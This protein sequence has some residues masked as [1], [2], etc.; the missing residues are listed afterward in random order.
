MIFQ[1]QGVGILYLVIL[2]MYKADKVKEELFNSHDI[3]PHFYIETNETNVFPIKVDQS[4]FSY[5]Y[6]V[7]GLVFVVILMF[8]TYPLAMYHY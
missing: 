5:M 1:F 6:L 3:D 8:I 4:T 7:F 2:M